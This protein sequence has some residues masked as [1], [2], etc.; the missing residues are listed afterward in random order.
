MKSLGQLLYD[1]RAAKEEFTRL[2]YD[3]PKIIGT[4]SVKVIKEGF[5]LQ[6]WDPG[7]GLQGWE[8]R[9]EK[10]NAAYD[11]YRGKGGKSKFKGSVYR[12]GNP[13]LLQTRNLYNSVKYGYAGNTV[14]IGVDACLIPYAKEMNEGGRGIPARKYMPKPGEAP[15]S[16]ILKAI[17]KKVTARINTAFKNFHK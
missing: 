8:P 14:T 4:E 5:K 16:K 11:R 10:T 7:T 13:L 12:S 1:F 3:I 6:G 15:T 9:S 17:E 2:N